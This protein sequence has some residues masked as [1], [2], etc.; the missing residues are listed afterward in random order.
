MLEIFIRG[1]A[2]A[3]IIAGVPK[4][5]KLD[6][7]KKTEIINNGKVYCGLLGCRVFLLYILGVVSVEMML[8]ACLGDSIQGA[9]VL[10]ITLIGS[11]PFEVFYI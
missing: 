9:I 7:Q 8:M 4:L 6:K 5:C 11:L 2:I 1:A 3:A 10:I